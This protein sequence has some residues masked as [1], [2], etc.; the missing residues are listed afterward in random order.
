M[1]L[2][3]FG[4]HNEHA[5]GVVL[6]DN[7]LKRTSGWACFPNA[8]A[9]VV[10]GTHELTSAGVWLTNLKKS[11][12]EESQLGRSNRYRMHDY[13]R[14]TLTQI[15]VEM[16]VAVID[17]RGFAHVS[18]PGPAKFFANLFAHVLDVSWRLGVQGFPPHQLRIG[19]R[20]V[21]YPSSRPEIDQI[22]A[23]ALAE[24]SD[25]FTVSER[26]HDYRKN[27]SAEISLTL[28]RHRYEHAREVVAQDVPY[29][30]WRTAPRMNINEIKY[31]P[32]PLLLQVEVHKMDP[33]LGRILNFGGTRTTRGAG[34]MLDA[35]PRKWMTGP[36][37]CFLSPYADISVIQILEGESYQRNPML[38]RLPEFGSD[39]SMSPA[40]LHAMESFWT[41]PLRAETG[42]TDNGP[43]AAWVTSYDRIACLRDALELLNRFPHS[44]IL[45]FGSGKIIVKIQDPQNNLGAWLLEAV[46]G[47][48]MIPPAVVNPLATKTNNVP[49]DSLTPV[50]ALQSIHTSGY[51]S[52][53]CYDLDV[54]ALDDWD[55]HQA[56]DEDEAP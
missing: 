51:A 54:A 47:T 46:E 7:A 30:T 3:T 23:T 42:H 15:A 27:T 26:Q 40:C 18:G 19:Y 2:P 9:F 52:Q 20:S 12:F 10:E 56:Y 8:D 17:G 50:E 31:H 45:G 48:Y 25:R 41:A 55:K 6:F 37:F 14:S 33:V 13:L 32:Q 1:S 34:A 24:A 53:C 22:V 16:G 29:G 36:E 43:I 28:V 35:R 5:P 11:E 39:Q 4:Q 38:D 44:D 49:M 21:H